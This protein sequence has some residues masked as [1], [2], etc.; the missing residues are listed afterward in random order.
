MNKPPPPLPKGFRRLR[1]NEILRK[2]DCL[3]ILTPSGWYKCG[4]T[5]AVGK[6]VLDLKFNSRFFRYGR[7][8]SR[9]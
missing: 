6:R 5:C 7:P 1:R 4:P 8:R 9:R 3:F 2:V